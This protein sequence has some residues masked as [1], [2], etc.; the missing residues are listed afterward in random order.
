MVEERNEAKVIQDTTR[1]IVSSAQVL[2][3]RAAGPRWPIET[4]N[5]G[6]NKSIPVTET[7][8]QPDYA[9]RFRR[10]AFTQ[11][12]LDRMQPVIGDIMDQSSFIATWYMYFPFLTCEVKCGAAA[13]DVAD[14]QNA[15]S[16]A[17]AVRA[18]VELFRAVK[19]ERELHREFLAFAI[20][21]DHR[22]VRL[23]GCYSDI[24]GPET[25]YY[26]HPIRTFDVTESDGKEK[27]T[28]HKF[29]KNVYDDWMLIHFKRM[30]S[31]IEQIPP[32]M[33]FS[34]SNPE[35]RFPEQPGLS[36]DFNAHSIAKSSL[37]S[38]SA[39]VRIETR[40]S[41]VDEHAATPNSSVT[42]GEV[43]KK[44]RKDHFRTSAR[45]QSQSS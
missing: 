35:L 28:A 43:F 33:S 17:V 40:S 18:V 26:R 39:Y 25:K 6:W 15:H 30:Y 1:L 20:S 5:E 32:D 3:L 41:L 37:D 9:V 12:Q 21:H 27:W 42:E 38:K 22:S 8:P 34:V 23:C 4:V 29:T 44:P 10:Q 24:D 13:L 19:R 2:A 11:V 7:K 31:A 45:T 14:R 16:A 36:Q